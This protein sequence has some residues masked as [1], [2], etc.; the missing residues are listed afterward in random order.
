[1]TETR[2][3][4]S[5]EI[6]F[7]EDFLKKL[8]YLFIV[9]KKVFAGKL[10]AERR[11]KKVGSGIEFA[12]HRDYAP[13]DDF[14]YVDWNVYGRMNKL[15]LRLF[16]EEE[17]LT[18]YLLLDASKSMRLG[19]PPKVDYARR[20]VA[21]LGYIALA[22]LDRVNIIPFADVLLPQL[23]PKRG[24]G[25]IFRVFEFLAAVSAGGLTDMEASF[26]SFVH[27]THRRGLA[28]VVSDFFDPHGYE[29]GLK[30]LR[31]NRFE[32]FAIQVCDPAEANP[33]VKGDLRLVDTETGE[34]QIA[35]VSP[36]VVAAYE[37]EFED[38]CRRLENFCTS[39]Q[40]GFVRTLT[41]TPFEDLVLKVFREGRFLK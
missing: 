41:S 7:D 16:E 23:T 18:V 27:Q 29:R 5:R 19:R 28:V 32:V 38:Y 30:L 24:K 15:L 10:R 39:I 26:K 35:T 31:H 14:R 4:T 25:Q 6:L 17:D 36:A 13:G 9:S 21:A 34:E 2:S 37:R 11:G 3:H 1:M 33:S 20:V 40:T 8:E 12:D 22:N